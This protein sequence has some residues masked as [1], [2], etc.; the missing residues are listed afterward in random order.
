[1]KFKILDPK[2]NVEAKCS[3][4]KSGKLGFS[5]GAAKKLSLETD[6]FF[7][8]AINE[9]DPND[10][11]LYLIRA[12]ELEEKAFNVLKAGEYFY[13]NLKH[14]FEQMGLKYQ[15]ESISY[16]VREVKEE[17][18]AYYHLMRREGDD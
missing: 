10:D 14:L 11:S 15:S 8:V 3:I 16:T 12:N 17:D 1:M 4:H 7:H 6:R 18:M 13:L 9:E 2:D 5:S